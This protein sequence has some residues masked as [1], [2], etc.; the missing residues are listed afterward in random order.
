MIPSAPTPLETHRGGLVVTLAGVPLVAGD[1]ALSVLTCNTNTLF[2]NISNKEPV[3]SE[4][5][6]C[7]GNTDD[8]FIQR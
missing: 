4:P 6:Y 2:G 1:M 3:R 5:L 7:L 8:H